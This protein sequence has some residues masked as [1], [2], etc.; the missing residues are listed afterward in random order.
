MRSDGGGVGGLLLGRD[1]DELR[2]GVERSL[3]MHPVVFHAD[4]GTFVSVRHELTGL[5]HVL[6]STLPGLRL[7]PVVVVSDH[8]V[9][10][11]G[12][13]LIRDLVQILVRHVEPFDP[14]VVMDDRVGHPLARLALPCS[15]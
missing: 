8:A 6:P 4:L 7:R 3:P 15:H 2:P 14:A 10:E 9:A 11:H 13:G 12:P 1:V 5:A